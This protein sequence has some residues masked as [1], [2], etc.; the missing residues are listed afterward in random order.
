MVIHTYKPPLWARAL[1]VVLGL[2]A[3]GIVLL[4]VGVP[5]IFAETVLCSMQ[6]ARRWIKKHSP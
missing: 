6:E 3:G 1:C 4:L 5:K 2:G